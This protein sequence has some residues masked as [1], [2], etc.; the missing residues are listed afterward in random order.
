MR[1]ALTLAL[2][3]LFPVPARAIAEWTV[4]SCFDADCDLERAMVR[5]LRQATAVGSTEK[6]NL[7]F[8]A[9][10]A[11]PVADDQR[12]CFSDEGV[13]GLEDP[14]LKSGI[15]QLDDSHHLLDTHFGKPRARAAAGGGLSE[16]EAKQLAAL[17]EK[18]EKLQAAIEALRAK[19][20]SGTDQARVNAQLD[21]LLALLAQVKAAGGTPGA[22]LDPKTAELLDALAKMD[23]ALGKYG[24]LKN[25]LE[26][27][28]P[29]LAPTL[30][31]ADAAAADAAATQSA[32]QD[33]LPAP[34]ATT[35]KD[36][37]EVDESEDVEVEEKDVDRLVGAVK[38]MAAEAD[39]EDDAPASSAP[40]AGPRIL[41][42][43]SER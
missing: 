19:N 6:V 34:P 23:E 14:R 13:G 16:A 42:P 20:S 37:V 8:L 10:R 36:E 3:L 21:E 11:A 43:T 18:N 39:D 2:V 25:F 17:R 33:A 31:Q 35:A 38:V 4:M 24:G 5:N 26:Q 30:A 15:E 7:V 41:E 28:R 9:D 29:D 1:L 12:E 27:A 22:G 32:A 40:D